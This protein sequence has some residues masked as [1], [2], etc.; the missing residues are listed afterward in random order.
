MEWISLQ[1]S[2]LEK[3][4]G[5]RLLHFSG[6]NEDQPYISFRKEQVW[7]L[8]TLRSGEVFIPSWQCHA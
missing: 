3:S 1:L 8:S 2:L 7:V 5:L 6:G 4:S